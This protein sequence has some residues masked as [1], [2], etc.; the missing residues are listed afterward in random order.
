M[1]S[2]KLLS[3]SEL[4]PPTSKGTGLWFNSRKISIDL[5]QNP[6][7]LLRASD[8][9]LGAAISSNDNVSAYPE[10]IAE[11]LERL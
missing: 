3:K 10:K 5:G 4:L 7:L 8:G 1:I 2:F 11:L 9:S 6:V